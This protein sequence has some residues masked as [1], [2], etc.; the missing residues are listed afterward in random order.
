MSEEF[1]WERKRRLSQYRAEWM[2]KQQ[3]ATQYLKA[4]KVL[5][6][7]SVPDDIALDVA[8]KIVTANIGP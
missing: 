7:K 4:M 1:S 8:H 6:D 3:Q 5:D 2:I